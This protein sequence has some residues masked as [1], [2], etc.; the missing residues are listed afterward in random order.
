MDCRQTILC[1]P[2]IWTGAQEYGKPD[3]RQSTFLKQKSFTKEAGKHGNPQNML[4]F[5]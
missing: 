5:S 1:M 2:K 4:R 3:T